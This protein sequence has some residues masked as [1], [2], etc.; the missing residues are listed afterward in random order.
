ML[1]TLFPPL[2]VTQLCKCLQV[3]SAQVFKWHLGPSITDYLKLGASPQ[4]SAHQDVLPG[5]PRERL[6]DCKQRWDLTETGAVHNGVIA[7][8]SFGDASLLQLCSLTKAFLNWG[9]RTKARYI[10]KE[11]SL[12]ITAEE[13]NPAGKKPVM[14]LK[15]SARCPGVLLREDKH[16]SLS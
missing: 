1:I 8:L 3:I 5:G 7:P 12:L 10:Q 14:G 13:I 11:G 4:C 9:K 15:T 6:R 2:S 16:K